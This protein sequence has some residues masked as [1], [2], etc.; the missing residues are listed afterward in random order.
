MD[1]SGIFKSHEEAGTAMQIITV[2]LGDGLYVDV[3]HRGDLW[4]VMEN[5]DG[6]LAYTAD[7]TSEELVDEAAVLRFV[8]KQI[9]A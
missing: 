4:Y 8:K 2:S 1:I 5:S 6:T 9:S 3:M 7:G